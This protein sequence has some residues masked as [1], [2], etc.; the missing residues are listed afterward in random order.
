MMDFLKRSTMTQPGMVRFRIPTKTQRRKTRRLRFQTLRIG[1]NATSRGK[2]LRGYNSYVSKGPRDEFEV[3]LFDVNYLGQK[4]YRYG[5]LAIDNFTKMMWVVPV[6]AKYGENFIEAM[7]AVIAS[8][9]GQPHK[10]YSDEEPAMVSSN[11][12]KEWLDKNNILHITTRSHANTAER[13]IRTFKDLMTRRLEAPGNED[14]KWWDTSV[15]VAV[16]N[17]YNQKMVNRV[18]GLTPFDA[19][20]PKTRPTL[21]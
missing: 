1:L 14:V 18:T 8:I 6:S 9:M 11:S 16:L 12:F 20:K 21:G 4:E 17:V 3:D 15:R 19:D 7:E 5:F 10:I 2:Q 13:A